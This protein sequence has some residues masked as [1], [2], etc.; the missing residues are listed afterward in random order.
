MIKSAR[1]LAAIA[2]VGA[3]AAVLAACTTSTG[4]GAVE[5]SSGASDYKLPAAGQK[6]LDEAM[7]QPKWTPP[8]SSPAPAKNKLVVAIPC[9]AAA[10]GCSRPAQA[11]LD[12]AKALGWKTQ[13]IDPQSDPQKMQAALKQAMQEGANAVYAPGPNVAQFSAALLAQARAQGIV[14]ATQGAHTEPL[15]PNGW[16]LVVNNEYGQRSPG[17]AAW[18]AN[19][20]GGTGQVLVIDNSEFLGTHTG[21]V[22]FDKTLKQICDKCKVA[23]TLDLAVADVSTSLPARI[24][25]S[26]QANPNINYIYSP[27]DFASVSIISAVEQ[28]G[29]ANKVKVVGIDGNPQNIQLLKQ[30]RQAA[31]YATAADLWSWEVAD[32]VNRIFQGQAPVAKNGIIDD[33]P[34]QLFDTKHQPSASAAKNGWNGGID[35]QADYKKL[36]ASGS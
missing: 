23:D 26:L 12:A 29:F 21:P 13:L 15:G 24:K 9:D 20:S 4:K 6:L 14:M 16:N 30:G 1:K 35:Y 8:S 34:S 5:Q 31:T 17:L 33:Y 18:V 32:N 19:D 27:F 25:A 10:V 3:V 11:F 2:L 36:W 7:A 28:A 22:N